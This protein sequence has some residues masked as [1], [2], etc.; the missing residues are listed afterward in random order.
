MIPAPRMEEAA[1]SELIDKI[2]T[3][4]A[5]WVEVI[6]KLCEPEVEPRYRRAH[7]RYPCNGE[8]KVWL[9]VDDCDTRQT[10][11]MTQVSSE[12]ISA[13]A[14]N[15]V[16][17]LVRVTIQWIQEHETI[18]LKGRVRHCTQTIGGYKVGVQLSF[19][20]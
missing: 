9:T 14:P 8:I 15:E 16:P 11:A 1:V 17:E 18:I 12:G 20:E 4:Y 10:W 19:S 6:S 5:R 13:I 7:R 2:E 3:P